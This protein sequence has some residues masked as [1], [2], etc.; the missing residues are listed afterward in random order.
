MYITTQEESRLN[1]NRLAQRASWVTANMPQTIQANIFSIKY[2][3]IR[4]GALAI[5]ASAF[6][7]PAV[8]IR[9]AV[10]W[11]PHWE[12]IACFFIIL[13]ALCLWSVLTHSRVPL[14]RAI[15]PMHLEIMVIWWVFGLVWSIT[16]YAIEGRIFDDM[17]A[18]TLTFWLISAVSG[19]LILAVIQQIWK[20]K[21]HFGPYCPGCSYCLIGATGDLCPECGRGFT[22]GELGISP[23]ELQVQTTTIPPKPT[24]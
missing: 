10:R 6:A 16:F 3:I 21:L 14:R 2:S 20:P 1:K 5:G 17:L 8:I 7:V 11:D 23:S 18:M 15:L 13:P 19:T 4:S 22:I 24:M 12:A 9:L